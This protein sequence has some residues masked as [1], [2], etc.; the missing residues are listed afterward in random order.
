[1]TI[2]LEVLCGFTIFALVVVGLLVRYGDRLNFFGPAGK[3]K[4]ELRLGD[5][6]EVVAVG[7]RLR[8]T[9]FSLR[10]TGTMA[11]DTVELMAG[12]YKFEY[13]FPAGEMVKIDLINVDDADTETV[14]LKSGSGSV[15]MS[16]EVGGRYVFQVDPANESTAWSF[17]CRP[18]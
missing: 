13:T 18:L 16:V 6:G 9:E 11:S 3:P 5:D 15:A 17:T 2:G 7:E 10:G 14:V 12:V 1:M 8:G 4:R